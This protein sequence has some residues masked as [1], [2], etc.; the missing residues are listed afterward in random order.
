MNALMGDVRVS[1]RLMVG[2][3]MSKVVGFSAV[4]GE[5]RSTSRPT[6]IGCYET[7]YNTQII[8]DACTIVVI[9]SWM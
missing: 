2:F 6:N 4:R 1:E 8:C 3:A 5:A 9:T 7:F